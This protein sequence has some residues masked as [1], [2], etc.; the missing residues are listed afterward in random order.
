VLAEAQRR[1]RRRPALRLRAGRGR[2]RAPLPRHRDHRLPRRLSLRDRRRAQPND[3]TRSLSCCRS[4]RETVGS[5]SAATAP[6]AAGASRPT[7][8]SAAPPVAKH[9]G[10][11][12][13]CARARRAARRHPGAKSMRRRAR[14]LCARS[15]RVRHAAQRS[16]RG[17]KGGTH[18]QGRRCSRP[19]PGRGAP[20]AAQS[21]DRPH[22]A[23]RLAP[24][25]PVR[26]RRAAA[27]RGRAPRPRRGRDPPARRGQPRRARPRFTLR[28][29]RGSS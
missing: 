16:H 8:C 11:H 26:P 15:K 17:G 27:R 2:G 28:S 19:R 14:R 20:L 29:R 7:T 25:R 18:R 1:H 9:V 6:A 12:K 5:P 23:H 10:I 22:L 3:A 24:C 13:R 4:N 21:L